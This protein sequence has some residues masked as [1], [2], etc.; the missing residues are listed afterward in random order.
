MPTPES[1]H[2]GRLGSRCRICRDSRED[3]KQNSTRG[4][5]SSRGKSKLRFP[6]VRL[7]KSPE[8]ILRKSGAGGKTLNTA[9]SIKGRSLSRKGKSK[10]SGA[11]RRCQAHHVCSQGWEGVRSAASSQGHGMNPIKKAPT[12]HRANGNTCQE[13]KSKVKDG[14][15]LLMFP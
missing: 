7:R 3:S 15:W 12:I 11:E 2:W 1:S 10:I 9:E 14:S 4:Q 5:W 8:E 6:T 13:F